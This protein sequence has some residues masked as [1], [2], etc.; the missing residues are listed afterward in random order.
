MIDMIRCATEDIVLGREGGGGAL[1]GFSFTSDSFSYWTERV[2]YQLL[3]SLSR[4]SVQKL[5]DGKLR[6]QLE[7]RASTDFLRTIR[8]PLFSSIHLMSVSL[9]FLYLSCTNADTLTLL[10][11]IWPRHSSSR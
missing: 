6:N 4:Y 10:L 5:L 1:A 8:F 9:P 7:M 3:Y 2:A 11:S